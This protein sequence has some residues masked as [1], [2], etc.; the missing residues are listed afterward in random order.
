MGKRGPAPTPTQTLRLRGSSALYGREDHLEPPA[1]TPKPPCKL[2]GV[3]AK[4]WK[5]L[6]SVLGGM[7]VL[8]DLDGHALAAYCRAWAQ[9]LTASNRILKDGPTVVND[10]DAE[11]PHPA[12]RSQE[13]AMRVMIQVGGRFGLTPSDRVRLP[14]QEEK[15]QAGKA[16]LFA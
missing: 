3:S 12:I 15:P 14:K 1:K 5:H 13:S 6:A 11:V 8:T 9:Y 10:K 7:G 4:A 16:R 2:T